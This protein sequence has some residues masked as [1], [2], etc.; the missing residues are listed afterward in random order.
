MK[1]LQI[2]SI[3]VVLA[4]CD[5]QFTAADGDSAATVDASAQDSGNVTPTGCTADSQCATGSYC[6]NGAC[7][8]G[9]HTDVN[10]GAGMTCVNG[11]C[12][13]TTPTGC[14]ADTQ[15]ATG[16][17]CTN[18][19]CT[20]GCRSDANCATGQQT[21]VNGH[22]Q[23]I[24]PPQDAGVQDC[25]VA[26]S[27]A[28]D[29][30]NPVTDSGTPG[31][32][33]L[34]YEPDPAGCAS[35]WVAMAWDADGTLRQSAP[36]TGLTVRTTTSWHGWVMMTQR[37]GSS[38][39]DWTSFLGQPASSAGVRV[40]RL[41]G[42]DITARTRVCRDTFSDSTGTD[43]RYIRPAGPVDVANFDRCPSR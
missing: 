15:C 37:C 20:E 13:S 16:N 40:I 1:T 31:V 18:G 8:A 30:G 33:E 35:G 10:C 21:C 38:W 27:G 11:A 4:G 9:C 39:R 36:G 17:I 24:Q 34:Y 41:N 22:C 2:V 12:R 26:D 5:M 6:A 42:V 28:V 19:T 43:N 14:T 25:G 23:A 3:M 29:S 7:L 32:M